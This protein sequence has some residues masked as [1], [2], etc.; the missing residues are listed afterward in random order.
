MKGLFPDVEREH[1]A[2]A[3]LLKGVL[4]RH[5]MAG[6]LYHTYVNQSSEISPCTC[7]ILS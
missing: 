3:D 1:P 6:C 4:F 2:W 5:T 7:H